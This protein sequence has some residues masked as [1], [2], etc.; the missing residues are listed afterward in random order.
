MTDALLDE[1]W[2]IERKKLE[3]SS[4]LLIRSV[5]SW[6]MAQLTPANLLFTIT[7]PQAAF[8]MLK[9]TNEIV[10]KRKIRHLIRL[11]LLSTIF[12]KGL[13]KETRQLGFL[14]D[15]TTSLNVDIGAHRE[16]RPDDRYL[17]EPHLAQNPCDSTPHSVD[18]I[19]I[20]GQKKHSSY[21]S[22]HSTSLS[23]V[24]KS[25]EIFYPHVHDADVTIW[26]EGDL[27]RADL[28]DDLSFPLL[29]C[30]LM[31]TS[32]WGL[33][34]GTINTFDPLLNGGWSMGYRYMIRFYAVTVW[35][36]LKSLG[37]NWMIRFDD[38]SQLMSMVPYNLFERMRSEK[39]I[40]GF[41]QMAMECGANHGTRFN[42]FVMG[43]A[44]KVNMTMG[45]TSYCSS[46]GQWGFYNNFYISSIDWWLD[47]K[48]IDFTRE[49][50]RSMLIFENR[51]NDLIFQTA[52]IRLFLMPIYRKHFIDFTYLHHTIVKDLVRYGGIESGTNDPNWE[53]TFDNY[54]RKYL[55]NLNLPD[56]KG[57]GGRLSSCQNLDTYCGDPDKY[58]VH[59]D[60][61][62]FLVSDKKFSCNTFFIFT[63]LAPNCLL[64]PS[65]DPVLLNPRFR[66]SWRP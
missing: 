9:E 47:P 57:L 13:G 3:N 49:F 40:Y 41:R 33:P 53:S 26:H 36:L 23:P 19:V 28:P 16:R 1:R 51:D 24:L 30:N 5:A 42:R 34:E 56:R 52:V 43:Y 50:D 35:E 29:M 7:S 31:K 63:G 27:T 2:A 20:L 14:S 39:K 37:F 64:R 22:T 38:D 46:A 18:A 48:V 32:A 62:T 66:V 8:R 17:P 6:S 61:K 45:S 10:M 58:D 54:T 12:G 25:L 21:D 11:F 59:V 55:W 44:H 15:I 60:A 4:G 65:Q